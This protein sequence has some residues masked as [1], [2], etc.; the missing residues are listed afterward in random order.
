MK[1]LFLDQSGKL[2]GAEL[3]LLDIA[4][5]YQNNCLVALLTDGEFT[6]IL[7]QSNIPVK[8]IT[9]QTIK[10]S[11]R[12]N[13]FQGIIGLTKIIPIITKIIPIARKYD[14]IY[15]NTQKALVI[16]A[17]TSFF[18]LRPLVYHLHDILSLTHFSKTN[19]KIAVI[20]ANRFASL[21]I[22]NSQASK[23][24]FFAAGGNQNLVKVVYNGFDIKQ[25]QIGS[26]LI[27]QARQE[28]E[29]KDKFVIGHFSRI[30]PW[31]GQH[32]LISALAKC[33]PHIIALLVGDALFGEHKYLQKLH[34]QVVELGLENRV[35]FLGFRHN[36]PQLMTACNLI[37]HTSIAPEP[38]G[39][40]IVEAMLCG[41]TVIASKAGGATE[42]V[43]NGKNG[44]LV[45]PGNAEELAY[46][47]T[48]CYHNQESIKVIGNQAKTIASQNFNIKQTN[49]QIHQLICQIL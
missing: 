9:K 42:L 17:I 43:E 29:I 16:G 38:F 33:P 13:L 22:A 24:A 20:L 26:N 11:K 10:T 40:V 36:I 46:I 27:Q 23:N 7:H 12:S 32:I 19:I 2:G 34:R 14:L 48:D 5:T 30:A 21:V 4:K 3:C 41:K 47:V 28:L 31:K 6:H 25:Y 45:T 39:R 8:V 35:R 37:A 44:L 49:Q 15:A 18:T 1:I